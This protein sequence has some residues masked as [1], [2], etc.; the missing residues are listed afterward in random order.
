ML[1]HTAEELQTFT[2]YILMGCSPDT[3]NEVKLQHSAKLSGH[4]YHLHELYIG[5]ELVLP[6]GLKCW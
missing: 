3:N 6:P 2:Y 5:S 4:S 1:D